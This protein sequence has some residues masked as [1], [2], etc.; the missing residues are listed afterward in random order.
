MPSMLSA[1]KCDVI[2][3]AAGIGEEDCRL[4]MHDREA[5]EESRNQVPKGHG[6]KEAIHIPPVGYH[7]PGDA[8]HNTPAARRT[9]TERKAGGGGGQG[10][11][12][13]QPGQEQRAQRLSGSAAQRLSEQESGIRSSGS[14]EHGARSAHYALS[15]MSNSIST[16]IQ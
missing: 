9:Q 11:G 15:T 13:H 6:A 12:T 4:Q 14:G 16:A 8:Q 10:A 7:Q 1:Y 3:G 5:I 2:C